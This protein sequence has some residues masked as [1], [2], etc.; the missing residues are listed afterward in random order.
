MHTNVLKQARQDR[1]DNNLAQ[2]SLKNEGRQ[3]LAGAETA[4]SKARVSEIT[5]KLDELA[6]RAVDI[7]ASIAAGERFIAD[8]IAAAGPGLSTPVARRSTGRTFAAMFPGVPLLGGGFANSE[9]FLASVH[10]G[11]AD[12]R[13]MHSYL[14]PQMLA[15]STTQV[16]SSGGFSVPTQYVA[17]WLDSAL[18][19]EI[20]RPRATVVPMT[21]ASAK[22]PGFDGDTRT[23]NLYGGFAG[24]WANEDSDLSIEHVRLKML[25]LRARKLGVVTQVS[26]EL[27]ADGLGFEMQLGEAITRALSFFLDD[28]F[29]NGNGA[30][31]PQGVIGAPCTI[32]V[33]KETNQAAATINY[34]NISKMFA[35]L[36]PG[37]HGNAVWVANSTC[38]PQLLELAVPIGTA[39]S[40]VPVLQQA[41]GGWSLLTRP[42]L[43]SEK[44]PT[45][46]TRGDIGLYDFS[47]Y[48][49]GLRADVTLDKS[50]HVG[51]V[52]D[53][54][55]YRAT[56][57]VDGMPR[58]TAPVQPKN[59]STLSAFTVLDTR[60]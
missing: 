32:S 29:F 55:T 26:N 41:G 9:A 17:Q 33:A 40:H 38:I 49:V 28:S 20:V 1:A 60:A 44:V 53:V 57:R 39:G 16:D 6:Q 22:F 2:A 14:S 54:A 37:S 24:G 7:E 46:G 5:A 11:L 27:V 25:T 56:I 13:L 48:L 23:S 12:P 10:S 47:Q 8:E 31:R 21:S 19:G 35:R 45:V 58:L 18:E 51:F 59:G 3:L 43:F 36:L 30:N 4:G 15:T 42:I 34:S 50:A 52:S